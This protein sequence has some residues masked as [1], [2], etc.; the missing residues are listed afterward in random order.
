LT[1]RNGR[2]VIAKKRKNGGLHGGV[3]DDIFVVKKYKMNNVVCGLYN[4]VDFR[5]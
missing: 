4:G 3:D 5:Q 2:T 1:E